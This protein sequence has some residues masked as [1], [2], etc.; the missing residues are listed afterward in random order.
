MFLLPVIGTRHRTCHRHRALQRP[1][2]AQAFSVVVLASALIALFCYALAT[3]T[4]STSFVESRP[5]NGLTPFAEHRIIVRMRSANHW[6]MLQQE[7]QA[8]HHAA[9]KRERPMSGGAWVASVAGAITEKALLAEFKRWQQI[10]LVD[11]AELDSLVQPSSVPNDPLFDLQWQLGD[12]SEQ[13]AAMN[14]IDAWAITQGSPEIV[15]A[16]VDTGVRFEHEDLTGRLLPGYDFV[17][18]INEVSTRRRVPDTLDF[19]KAH[20]G[21]GRDED[22]TDPGDGVDRDTHTLMTSHDLECPLQ[23]SSWHGTAMASLIAA[24]GND[25]VGMTGIDWSASILPVRAIGRCGGRRSDLLDAIRWAAGV[26][27]P[28]LPPN[29]TPA[30]VINL[31][32]GIDDRCSASDQRAI[33]DAVAA[34][35]VIVAAVGNLTRNLDLAPSSPAHCNNVLGITAV[36]SHGMR[37]SY[38]SYGRDAD[39]A[40]PGGE[41]ANGEIQ[42]ILIATNRGNQLPVAGS[43]HEFSTGTSIATPLVSG[44]ISLMLSVNPDLSAAEISALLKS[45]A[46]PFPDTPATEDKQN[47]NEFARTTTSNSRCTPDTCGSGIVDAAAAVNAALTFDSSQPGP[48]AAAI[49]DDQPIL[50]SGGGAGSMNLWILVLLGVLV[51]SMGMPSRRYTLI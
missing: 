9:L 1:D 50:S 35:A 23:E 3:H 33:N 28:L 42:P 5:D 22:A 36:D 39:L 41:V 26:E 44:V 20:D 45:T 47:E 49:Q 40:A 4:S 32:L 18:G 21:D 27:D 17:S 10:S 6:Q 19:V 7:F 37:A 38:S 31:S 43:S 16:I 24:N 8:R 46:R 12:N 11:Y 13:I 29:P 14:L 25:A 15:V 51:W 2:V 34:G 48:L 30:H